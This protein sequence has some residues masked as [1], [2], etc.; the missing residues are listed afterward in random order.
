MTTSFFRH[1]L[2]PLLLAVI[3]APG[4]FLGVAEAQSLDDLLSGQPSALGGK[5]KSKVKP[6]AKAEL[7]SLP[8]TEAEQLVELRVTVKLPQGCYIY[9]MDGEFAGRTVIETT[10]NGLEPMSE[11]QPDR[12]GKQSHDPVFDIDLTKFEDE[13]TWS[14]RYRFVSNGPAQAGA[15]GNNTVQISGTVTG[16][17]CS[18][19]GEGGGQCFPLIPFTASLAENRSSATSSPGGPS[20]ETLRAIV[21]TVRPER[22]K[23]PGPIALTFT[24][25]PVPDEAG[26]LRLSILAELDKG[27][28]TFS[29]TQSDI[30]GS[31]TEINITQVSGLKPIAEG[32][33][34][35]PPFTI[36]EP[37]PDT[38]LEIHEP[39]VTWSRDYQITGSQP[40]GIAGEISYQVCKDGTCLPLK[41]VPFSIGTAQFAQQLTPS[42]EKATVGS[43][44]SN[45]MSPS[46]GSPATAIAK[47]DSQTPDRTSTGPRPLASD[48]WGILLLSI[49]GGYAA[50]LTP[51]VFPMIPITV[52]FFLKQGSTN[53][54]RTLSLAVVYSLSIIIAFTV[55][56][57]GLSVIFGVT[58]LNSLSNNPWLNSFIG[59]VFIAFGFNMLGV[60]EI[61]IPSSLLTFTANRGGGGGYIGV[62]FMALTFTLT[63]FTCTFA[64]VASLMAGAA[65]GSILHPIVGMLGFST[66]FAS[67]FFFLALFPGWLQSLPRSGGWMYRVKVVLGLIELGAALKFLSMADQAWNPTPMVFD[68]TLVML[69]WAAISLVAAMYLL[70]SFRLPHDRPD[71]PVSVTQLMFS[72][73]FM[74]L[75]GFLGIGLLAPERSSGL[76]LPQILAFAPPRFE[77]TPTP[78][79]TSG[80][81][82]VADH[83]PGP[84]QTHHGLRFAMDT[85]EAIAFAKAKQ[86]PLFLDFTG[87]N[88]VN[89]RLMEQKMA[90]PDL[91]ERLQKFVRVQAYTDIVPLIADRAYAKRLLEGNIQLQLKLFGE[92]ALPTYAILST[93][94][95]TLLASYSGLELVD[96]E[97]ARFLDDGWQR[98]QAQQ[99]VALTKP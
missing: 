52:G 21:Q 66:A 33:T 29:L 18:A 19:A 16:Q 32:F 83:P 30:G 24:L 84:M 26:K 41:T 76:I 72:L 88:C 28:H 65:Q 22:N 48:L 91:H 96:G 44:D 58:F 2:L 6:T 87:V 39:A 34:A 9:G 40:I 82:S 42:T 80:S 70:G 98:W 14:R 81:Q 63:S 13:V 35:D 17:Y 15:T 61:V 79:V 78:I 71:E 3:I 47:P 10:A 73:A 12:P 56:G 94:G 1:L 54:R 7:V 49:A 60:F 38:K 50:L 45:A 20:A 4:Q 8:A 62:I 90:A 11:F 55:F 27:W 74:T 85:Q 57:L 53:P 77:N 86:L 51:C 43:P 5:P 67:P 75:A 93:D 46:V 59:L 25:A 97:F 95:E 37:L 64:I 99:G 68:F 36:D 23:K 92:V 31:P 69:L 89:C